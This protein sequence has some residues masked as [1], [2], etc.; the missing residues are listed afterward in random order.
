MAPLD[1]RRAAAGNLAAATGVNII[2][3][4]LQPTNNQRATD[5]QERSYLV[6]LVLLN[7]PSRHVQRAGKKEWHRTDGADE[8]ISRLVRVRDKQWDR[9]GDGPE[10]SLRSEA[11]R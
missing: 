8:G 2:S 6:W 9:H 4:V 10:Y 3:F 11:P 7:G 1:A 5:L